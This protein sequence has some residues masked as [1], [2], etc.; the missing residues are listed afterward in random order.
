M[1]RRLPASASDA[2]IE[3]LDLFTRFV[4]ARS[5][6]GYSSVMPLSRNT[7]DQRSSSER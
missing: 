2:K 3:A 1:R 5:S 4:S 7:F 6:S